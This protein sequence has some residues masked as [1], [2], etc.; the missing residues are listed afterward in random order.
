M[1]MGYTFRCSKCGYELEAYLGIGFL[2]IRQ[3]EETIR[4]IKSGKYGAKAKA[5]FE[6]HPD[7]SVDCSNALFKCEKC[8][9]LKV[10]PVLDLYKRKEG[11]P[12]PEFPFPDEDYFIKDT[13]F[14]HICEKSG[15][16][17]KIQ[18]MDRFLNRV[19][20]GKIRCPDCDGHLELGELINWD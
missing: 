12:E 17:M 14:E 3:T 16:V 5:F 18:N 4:K 9:S 2:F 8:G 20:K 11:T 7:G 6:E 10:E 1:G 19:M 13:E 15:T